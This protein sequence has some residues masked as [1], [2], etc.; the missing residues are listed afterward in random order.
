MRPCLPAR[1]LGNSLAA[2]VRLNALQPG[3]VAAAL[4]ELAGDLPELLLLSAAQVTLA[5]PAL[6]GAKYYAKVELAPGEWVE[7]AVAK[8]TACKCPRCWRYCAEK[9]E[10]LCTRC[11]G[12]TQ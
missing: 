2:T 11:D 6:A 9:E 7:I 4:A 1:L 3:A 8:A 10:A 12:A 5:G